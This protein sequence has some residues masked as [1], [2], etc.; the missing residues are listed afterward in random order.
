MR[1]GMGLGLTN[2][3]DAGRTPGG[4][5][6]LATCQFHISDDIQA[7]VEACKTQMR[8]AAAQGSD[9]VHFSETCLSGYAGVEHT[10]FEGFDW[11]GLVAGTTEVQ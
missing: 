7:N 3:S 4:R 1:R 5:L 9:L 10:S 8:K 6:T 11:P 2:Q